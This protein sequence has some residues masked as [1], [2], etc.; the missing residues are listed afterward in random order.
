MPRR[1]LTCPGKAK[2]SISHAE[3]AEQSLAATIRK[4]DSNAETAEDAEKIKR[5]SAKP[6]DRTGL[7]G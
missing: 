4:E 5:S 1:M 2:R 6:I 3:A 7:A